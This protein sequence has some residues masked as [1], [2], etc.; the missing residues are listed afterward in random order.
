MSTCPAGKQFPQ[1][2][3]VGFSGDAFHSSYFSFLHLLFPVL[4]GERGNSVP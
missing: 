4:S 3:W 1:A 2:V